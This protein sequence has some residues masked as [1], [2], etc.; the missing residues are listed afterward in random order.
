MNLQ[1][2]LRSWLRAG[3]GLRLIVLLGLSGMALIL[4][5]SMFASGSKASTSTSTADASAPVQSA[6]ADAA[7][8]AAKMESRLTAWLTQMEGVGAVTV[9]VTVRGTAEQI[10]AEEVRASQNGSGKQSENAYVITKSGGNESALVAQTRY[11]AIAGVAVLC[12]GGDRPAVQE[13]VIRAVSTVLGI[14]TSDIFVGRSASAA[15]N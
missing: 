5:S 2:R 8:Y 4:L 14:P 1:E 6:D 7:E 11:P 13:R 12:T 10:Y 9:M 3:N 15:A